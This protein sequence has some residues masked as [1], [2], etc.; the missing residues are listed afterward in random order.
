MVFNSYLSKN[1]FIIDSVFTSFDFI[2]LVLSVLL[3]AAGGYIINDLIDVSTDKVNKPKKNMFENTN[4]SVGKKYYII[5]SIS[6]IALSF[7]LAYK[8]GNYQIASIHIVSAGLLYLYSTSLKKY[9]GLGNVVIALLAALV[10]ITYFLFEGYS[11]LSTYSYVLNESYINIWQRGPL[12]LL[13]KWSVFLA[14]F[15]FALTLCREIVKDIEDKEGD[16][17]TDRKTVPMY[18]GDKN[19]I[20]LILSFLIFTLIF[21]KNQIVDLPLPL[22]LLNV[23]KYYVIAILSILIIFIIIHQKVKG[24]NAKLYSKALKITMFLGICSS[25]I[26]YLNL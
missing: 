24:V 22:D 19:S 16:L 20:Y 25:I 21:A 9:V 23:I 15:A 18:I 14:T 2:L 17:T 11:F 8:I 5:T 3:I 6:G 10:P 12:A 4:E 26:I 7:Y 13:W 1:K